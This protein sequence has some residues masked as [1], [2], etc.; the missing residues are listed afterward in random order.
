MCL[1]FSIMQSTSALKAVDRGRGDLKGRQC[2]ARCPG[3]SSRGGEGAERG[4]LPT[5]QGGKA[6]ALAP[7]SGEAKSASAI[8]SAAAAG[9]G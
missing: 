5:G 7:F 4:Q 6:P 8:C 1:K 9:T 3:C 2:Q